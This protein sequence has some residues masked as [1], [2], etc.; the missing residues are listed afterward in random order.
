MVDADDVYMDDVDVINAVGW[1][2]SPCAVVDDV[3]DDVVDDD[4]T[5]IVDD[6]AADEV[7]DVD[8]MTLMTLMLM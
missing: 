7:D 8:V 3:D 1:C 5:D 4:D 2:W 6:V